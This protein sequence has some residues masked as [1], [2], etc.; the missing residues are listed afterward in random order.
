MAV[1]I[2]N[3]APTKALKVKTTFEAW[4]GRRPNV[5]FLRTFGCISH[6]KNTKPCL[7]K[8]EDRSTPM[9]LLGYEEGSKAYRLY[10]PKTGK[11]VISTVVVFDE[12]AAWDWVQH[13]T[14]EAGGVSSTFTIEHMVMQG[15]DGAGAQAT[16]AAVGA[17][18]AAAEDCCWR[19]VSTSSS[20]FTSTIVPRDSRTGDTTTGIRFSTHRHRRVRGCFP[21]WRG[22]PV[23]TRGQHYRRRASSWVG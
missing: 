23:Q 5:S 20:A 8:L 9:V 12:M 2:L 19:A 16:T 11:V 14:G 15:G 10:D 1:F 17:Q 7:G 3:R 21:R 22:G 18:A 13:G 4:H 6:V